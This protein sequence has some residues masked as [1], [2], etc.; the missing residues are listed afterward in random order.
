M[1]TTA[2]RVTAD[3]RPG[4]RSVTPPQSAADETSMVAMVGHEL[5]APLATLS[6]AA[7]MLETAGSPESERLIAVVNRQVRRLVWLF[8]AALRATAIT[9]GCPIDP[10]A[11]S[12]VD[13]VIDDVAAA[14]AEH[15]MRIR[16]VVDCASGLPE[17][18]IESKALTIV[19]N[20]VVANALK[21]SGASVIRITAR[22]HQDVS[23]IVVEDDGCGVP[24]HLR[25]SVFE[26]GTRRLEGDST[27]LGLHVS[28]TLLQ[29]FGGEISLRASE[30]GGAAFVIDL[31]A[32]EGRNA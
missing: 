9:S 12:A 16:I 11:R 21:H 6:A 19:L 32:V 2:V 14:L 5:R 24:E 29:R 8:D 1:S 18:R 10:D 25:G 4:I 17:A 15:D 28:R 20:N 23:R 31:P 27:G 7:E 22:S 26:M 13:G 30:C 3:P